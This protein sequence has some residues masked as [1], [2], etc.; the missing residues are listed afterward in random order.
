MSH[1]RRPEGSGEQRSSDRATAHANCTGNLCESRHISSPRDSAKSP[2]PTVARIWLVRRQDSKATKANSYSTPS[3]GFVKSNPV[4][5][6]TAPSSRVIFHRK[7]SNRPSLPL[8]IEVN[9]AVPAAARF[10]VE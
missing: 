9:E 5:S 1:K 10:G 2:G 3:S 6:S 8:R 4:R 7:T